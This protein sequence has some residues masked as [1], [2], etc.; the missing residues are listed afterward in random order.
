MNNEKNKKIK[1]MANNMRKNI[2]EMRFKRRR[3]KFT[4]WRRVINCGY[5]SYSLW[6]HNA[7]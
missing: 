7:Y 6:R 5:C 4:L 1:A 2:L 3:T